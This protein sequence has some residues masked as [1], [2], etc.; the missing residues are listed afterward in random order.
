MDPDQKPADLDL[1]SFQK[2]I[3]LGFSTGA[4][5]GFL[6]RGFICSKVLGFV[7]LILSDFS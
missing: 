6:E 5:S 2:M 3:K 4:D 7:L 1:Q